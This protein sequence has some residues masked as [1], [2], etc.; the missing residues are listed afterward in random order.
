VRWLA[1]SYATN[2]ELDL[3][4]RYT[5]GLGL[6]KALIDNNRQ[7][8]L[9]FFGIQGATELDQTDTGVSTERLNSVEGVLGAS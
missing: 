6:G 1:A 4:Y 2:D 8:M 9:G 5:P 3:D 7:S